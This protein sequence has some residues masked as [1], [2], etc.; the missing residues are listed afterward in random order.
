MSVP[1]GGGGLM[2]LFVRHRNAANL[3]MALLIIGG[4]AA[5]MRMNTQFFPNFGLDWVKVS[6]VWPAAN[7]RDVDAKIVQLVEPELRFL[8]GV[9]RVIASSREGVGSVTVEFVAGTDMRKAQAD[10]EQAVSRITNLPEDAEEPTIFRLVRYDPISRLMISGPYSEAA[11][12]SW[13]K[14]IR[15]GLL[16]AGVEKV[17]IVGARDEEIL[18]ET[19]QSDLIRFGFSIDA[20]ARRLAD[21]SL[22]LP[23][24]DISGEMR[25]QLRLLGL[26]ETAAELAGRE[27]RAWPDGQRLLLGDVAK[28][29]EA[30]DEDAVSGWY[31]GRPALELVIQRA[32]TSDA[33]EAAAR[34][35][36]YLARASGAWPRDLVVRQ[37]DIR[38]SYIKERIELL[39]RNGAGGLVLVLIV[40]FLF[41]NGRVA[42]WVAMGIPVALFG[43]MP[44]MLMTGQSI[45]M[46]S[47]F[48]LIMTLGIIVDDAIVVGEHATTLRSRGLRP[49]DAALQGARRMFWPVTAASLTTIAAFLPLLVIGDAI[50]QIIVA[51]PYAVVAVLIASLIECFL[52]LPA[53]LRHGLRHDPARPGRFRRAFDSAFNRFRDGPFARAVDMAIRWRY[54]TVAGAVAIL[55]LSLSIVA[56][57]RLK[58]TFF[59]APETDVVLVNVLMAPGTPRSETGRM[60]AEV[61]RALVKTMADLQ[62]EGAPPLVNAR[63]GKLGEARI[64][65]FLSLRGDH[66]AS[67]LAELSPSEIRSVRTRRF[68]DAW[69]REIRPIAGLERLTLKERIG[70]PPG[71]ELDI[72]L[73]GGDYDALKAAAVKVEELLKAYDGV[74]D[75][76]DDLPAGKREVVLSLNDRGRALGL[77]TRSLARQLRDG[78]EGRIAQRFA[79]GDEEVTVRVRLAAADRTAKGFANLYVRTDAGRWVRLLDVADIREQAGFE[80][81]RRENGRREV[82]VTAE[83]D[84]NRTNANEVIASLEAGPLQKVLAPFG[85]SYRFAGKREEQENTMADMRFGAA[86]AV[87]SIYFI[88]AWVFS[89]YARPLVVM[90]I[91]P[92]GVVGAILGHYWLGYDLTILSNIALIGLAGVLVNDSIVLVSTIDEYIAEG[93]TPLEAVRDACRSRLRAVLLTSVTT[94]A[95][96]LPLMFETSVQA[97]FL[98]PMAITMVFGLGVATLLVLFLIPALVAIQLDFAGL[99][100][101]RR[102]KGSVPPE[103]RRQ[104][105]EDGKDFQPAQ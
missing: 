61:D 49:A 19:R 6:I 31:G 70:G 90:S 68:I 33:L 60:L 71:R 29:R 77:T 98:I 34:V 59:P 55:I 20:L 91:I 73:Q 47:L 10:V 25:K 72:R 75:I 93:E 30:Y 28:L 18:A 15:D 40:L 88:L 66:Y 23:A 48:A 50:G 37:Y 21:A 42:F 2:A 95:G 24:G 44:V 56:G 51:I 8:D 22:D 7:A 4:V 82:A 36:D 81:L 11:L 97:Q 94:I 27:I 69:R 105:G 89:S 80:T 74:S 99:F 41:L 67:M 85:L 45:N 87:A 26:S 63:F 3:L 53:H 96:L 79:R 54:V 9:K 92:F 65:D 58:M 62:E 83:I 104:Q 46:V 38:A 102:K 84:E 13:A 32:S 78:F 86:L 103:T 1:G 35:N 16:G 76:G 101:G 14:R 64:N 12:K 39:L 52:V 57:G 43:T 5:L 100:G 17:T